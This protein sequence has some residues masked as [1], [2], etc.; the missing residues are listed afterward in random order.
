M[1]ILILGQNYIIWYINNGHIEDSARIILSDILIMVILLLIM[2]ILSHYLNY[3]VLVQKQNS[4]GPTTSIN[5]EM[6]LISFDFSSDSQQILQQILHQTWQ[7]LP[8][9]FQ[10]CRL[11]CIIAPVIL[12]HFNKHTPSTCFYFPEDPS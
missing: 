11:S 12:G 1:V 7:R 9:T 5:R 4:F 6:Q 8:G 3:N 2:F 10:G